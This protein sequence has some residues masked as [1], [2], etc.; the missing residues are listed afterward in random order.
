MSEPQPWSLLSPYPLPPLSSVSPPS[1][2]AVPADSPPDQQSNPAPY[3]PPLEPAMPA[4]RPSPNLA[5]RRRRRIYPS[6]KHAIWHGK[7]WLR[8][9][10]AT[11]KL[12]T[13]NWGRWR[14]SAFCSRFLFCTSVGLRSFPINQA[15]SHGEGCANGPCRWLGAIC[16]ILLPIQY[17]DCS[18]CSNVCIMAYHSMGFDLSIICNSGAESHCIMSE[19]IEFETKSLSLTSGG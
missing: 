10:D 7:K 14:G 18:W 3:S 9:T 8:S 19:R 15:Y 1:P 5:K 4:A 11:R 2:S 13:G 12:W 16:P 17:N 6:L